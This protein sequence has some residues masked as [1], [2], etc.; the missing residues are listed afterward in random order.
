MKKILLQIDESF[1]PR[2]LDSAPQRGV[3]HR[4]Q[5]VLNDFMENWEERCAY[6]HKLRIC[7]PKQTLTQSAYKHGQV[8]LGQ[9]HPRQGEEGAEEVAH[10][11]GG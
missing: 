10:A 4:D 11:K 9:C 3:C 2:K 6:L 1:H 5:L 8:R 7:S